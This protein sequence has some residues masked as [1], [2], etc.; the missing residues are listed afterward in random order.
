MF[1]VTGCGG[2]CRETFRGGTLLLVCMRL[3][4]HAPYEAHANGVG[5]DVTAMALPVCCAWLLTG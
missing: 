4:M 3:Q 5:S 1:E 2:A